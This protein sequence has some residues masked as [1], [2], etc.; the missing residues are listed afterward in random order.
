[1]P[2]LRRR[3][4]IYQASPASGIPRETVVRAAKRELDLLKSADH[5]GIL[6]V[7]DYA[8]HELGPAL[9]FSLGGLALSSVVDAVPETLQVLVKR[10]LGTGSTA[11]AFLVER[12][13]RELVLKLALTPEHRSRLEAEAEVL[14]QLSHPGIVG[15]HGKVEM[16]GRLVPRAEGDSPPAT[17][18]LLTTWG[19]P[20]AG[21]TGRRPP[22][23][24]LR[25]LALPV[26]T[27]N[28]WARI[29]AA[30]IEHANHGN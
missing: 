25:L 3:I 26:L 15:F 30:W 7:L 24:P 5:P 9:L 20:R 22:P 13:R 27:P 19:S 10:K 17:S 16:Y 6:R 29:P 2:D 14:S 21:R 1:M 18:S 8:E 11:M 12:D 4:R 23:R 28:Q